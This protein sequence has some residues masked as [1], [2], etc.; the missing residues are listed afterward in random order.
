[1]P[2]TRGSE[3]AQQKLAAEARRLVV[4]VLDRGIFNRSEAGW[5]AA[6]LGVWA[7]LQPAAE[8]AN[9]VD[10]CRCDGACGCRQICGGCK[11]SCGGPIGGPGGIRE[12]RG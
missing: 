9:C 12:A 10:V 8:G 4:Q 2:K 6:A 7:S 5:V 11:A 1:M 3:K